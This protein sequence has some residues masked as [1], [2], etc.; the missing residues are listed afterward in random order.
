LPLLSLGQYGEMGATPNGGNAVAPS[1]TR[2]AIDYIGSGHK[3]VQ[4]FVFWKN[5][6]NDPL[7]NIARQEMKA[8]IIPS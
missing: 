4:R 2:I 1:Y 7:S 8:G 3:K 6:F 5:K